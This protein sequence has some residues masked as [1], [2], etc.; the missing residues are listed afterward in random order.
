MNISRKFGLVVFLFLMSVNVFGA[1]GIDDCINAENLFCGQ[2]LEPQLLEKYPQIFDRWGKRLTLKGKNGQKKF[3]D[4]INEVDASFE[5]DFV[6]GHYF[7]LL[8]YWPESNWALISEQSCQGE[9]M[10]PYLIDM[11]ADMQQFDVCGWPVFSPNNKFVAA[12][13]LDIGAGYF[14]NGIK[15]FTITENRKLVEVASFY[16]GE[17]DDW[18]V[19]QAT[20]K[21]NDHLVLETEGWCKTADAQQEANDYCQEQRDIVL[22]NGTWQ[23]Q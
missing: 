3:F 9:C 5:N 15:I 7:Y 19:K 6:D 17:S 16:T 21:A 2:L 11:Q 10:S 12:Y 23:L 22:K 18:G 4:N 1:D 20:W 8:N 14:F 13:N